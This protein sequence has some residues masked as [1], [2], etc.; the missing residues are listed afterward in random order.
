MGRQ[1][2]LV[3]NLKDQLTK[4]Q[5]KHF[6]A[7]RNIEARE[8]EL[9]E[10]QGQLAALQKASADGQLI[11]SQQLAALQETILQREAALAAALEQSKLLNASLRVA[12]NALTGKTGNLTETQ[13]QLQQEKANRAIVNQALASHKAN[14][15]KQQGNRNAQNAQIR[16]LT[17]QIDGLVTAFGIGKKVRYPSKNNVD[18][19]A[20]LKNILQDIQN[21]INALKEQYI[22]TYGNDYAIAFRSGTSIA[23]LKNTAQKAKNFNELKVAIDDALTKIPANYANLIE[24]VRRAPN[25][26]RVRTILSESEQRTRN[27]MRQEKITQAK[28][29]INAMGKGLVNNDVKFFKNRLD[30]ISENKNIDTSIQGILGDVQREVNTQMA[31]ITRLT[32]YITEKREKYHLIDQIDLGGKSVVDLRKYRQMIDNYADKYNQYQINI[33]TG[34]KNNQRS[35][36]ILSKKLQS[37]TNNKQ[38]KT[39]ETNIENRKKFV[40][41]RNTVQKSLNS[42]V[43]TNNIK[44]QLQEEINQANTTNTLD[45]IEESIASAIRSKLEANARQKKNENNRREQ[46]RRKEIENAKLSS[47]GGL[48]KEIFNV[49][50]RLGIKSDNE[51]VVNTWIINGVPADVPTLRDILDKIRIWEKIVGIRVRLGVDKKELLKSNTWRDSTVT[52]LETDLHNYERDLRQ[53]IQDINKVWTEI[54]NKAISEKNKAVSSASIDILSEFPNDINTYL[55][56]QYGLPMVKKTITDEDT[57]LILSER[58]LDTLKNINTNIETK[59]R[60]VKTWISLI[61]SQGFNGLNRRTDPASRLKDVQKLYECAPYTANIIIRYLEK[62]REKTPIN[63]KDAI[64]IC[65][66]L[67]TRFTQSVDDPVSHPIKINKRNRR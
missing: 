26:N 47:V 55:N 16:N 14:V 59:V 65:A 5:E 67:R 63:E 27:S 6:L 33:N 29:N 54:I 31:E 9:A 2:A 25:L 20:H 37:I 51:N 4:E 41:K 23:N 43:L 10:S 39:I 15:A 17:G 61:S 49:Q 56:T 19:V 45:T 30:N 28:L 34:F 66:K 50:R 3:Q 44:Q 22:T 62:Y 7:S 8:T 53:R 24:G 64:K 52:D 38:L 1:T 11:S 35:V 46:A 36:N 12:Q 57:T 32:K 60:D 42:T 13:R 58:L 48:Q 40:G 18:Y 21:E